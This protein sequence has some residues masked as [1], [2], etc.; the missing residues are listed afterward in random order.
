MRLTAKAEEGVIVGAAA[1]T[2]A[3][4]GC[5]GGEAQLEVEVEIELVV[6]GGHVGVVHGEGE[7]VLVMLGVREVRGVREVGF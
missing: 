2:A 5:V 6:E 4:A 7:H 1:G 3:A